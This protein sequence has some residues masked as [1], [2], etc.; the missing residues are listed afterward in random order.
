VRANSLD[1]HEWFERGGGVQRERVVEEVAG[2]AEYQH[3]Q[4]DA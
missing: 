3:E 1:T 2:A 4:T